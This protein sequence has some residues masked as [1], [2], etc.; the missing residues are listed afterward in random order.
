MSIVRK[1]V[2]VASA[3]FSF[4]LLAD[5]N[6]DV[7]VPS[8]I[9]EN[10]IFW[11]DASKSD[12]LGTN[13]NG[14]VT[15]WTSRDK[16][17]VVADV[18]YRN[19]S[20]PKYDN[21]TWT[22]PTVDFGDVGSGMDLGFTKLENIRTV[23]AVI[24]LAKTSNA[25]LLGAAN[26]GEIYHFHRGGDGAYA[27]TGYSRFSKIWNGFDQVGN[28]GEEYPDPDKFVVLTAEMN[29]ACTA[30]SLTNDR[31][32]A[33]RNG[34][35]QLSELICF[36]EVLDN[37]DRNAV[38]NYLQTK[39]RNKWLGTCDVAI[40]GLGDTVISRDGGETW[41][42]VHEFAAGSAVLTL[43]VKSSSA[44][45]CVYAWQGLPENAVFS[46]DRR[47]EV[48]FDPLFLKKVD[49]SCKSVPASEYTILDWMETN[50]RNWIDT[51]VK[52]KNGLVISA[53]I[54]LLSADP[55][56]GV[57][58]ACVGDGALAFLSRGSGSDAWNSLRISHPGYSNKEVSFTHTYDIYNGPHKRYVY[59]LEN[60]V[61]SNGI[62]TYGETLEETV[63]ESESNICLA[64]VGGGSFSPAPLLVYGLDI[65]DKAA[66]EYLRRMVPVRRVS[67]GVTGM[68]DLLNDEFYQPCCEEGGTEPFVPGAEASC[69]TSG[70]SAFGGWR[71]ALTVSGYKG[72]EV[73]SKVPVLVRISSDTIPGFAY[74][75]KFNSGEDVFFALDRKGKER[76]ACD[77]DT[78]NPG[79]ESLVWVKLPRLAGKDTMFYMF[80]GGKTAAVRP[81]STEVWSS[82]VAV[83][84]MNSYDG[85]TGV[86]DETGHGYNVTNDTG[87]STVAVNSD[88]WAFG[89]ALEL[90]TGQ[91][92]AANYDTYVNIT[93][94]MPD[95]LTVSGWWKMEKP[96]KPWAS[97]FDKYLSFENGKRRYGW[98]CSIGTTE[99][100]HYFQYG[101]YADR[102]LAKYYIQTDLSETFT[103]SW[104]YTSASSDGFTQNLTSIQNAGKVEV[105]NNSAKVVAH[106][107]GK[108]DLPVV[109]G[110]GGGKQTALDEIRIARDAYSSDRVQAD[111]DMMTKND[112]VKA[113]GAAEKIAGRGLAIIVR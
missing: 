59:R 60:G 97:F 12:T 35:R 89:P 63:F 82:Y 44:E 40:S 25:F 92:R 58:G 15:S 79:G 104:T 70:D 50:G 31:L 29:G 36:S 81:P 110:G 53:D 13:E 74:S 14:F 56:Q 43:R 1:F 32:I 11:L 67:D 90:T 54:R 101:N 83:W 21:K 71:I 75:E 86:Y 62:S 111:C 27:D 48:T 39:W 84:H 91:M 99:K 61:L 78:W 113:V 47:T 22:M 103:T 96:Y 106:T 7:T 72:A 107:V 76:L 65:F 6:T 45:N 41:S 94:N 95:I 28:I 112:F 38:I 19:M 30:D 3:A 57:F 42:A 10:A 98:Q 100:T 4:V 66:G 102:D 73:L 109:L 17:K 51:E 5:S 18:L 77:I 8:F 108:T 105:N 2:L 55:G 20:Y 80:W 34:G 26:S 68:L 88:S 37:D 24:R 9:D 52:A 23:F 33:G 16:N 46:D 64:S 93:N 49:I 87:A 69:T 85:E